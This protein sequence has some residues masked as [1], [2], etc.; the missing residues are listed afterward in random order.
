[1]AQACL[2]HTQGDAGCALIWESCGVEATVPQQQ[3]QQARGG[4]P[5]EVQVKARKVPREGEVVRSWM[6]R[7]GRLR[8]V[9]VD[10]LESLH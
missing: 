8:C 5:L 3:P 4:R 7:E 1:M 6:E 10:V 2:A 9:P